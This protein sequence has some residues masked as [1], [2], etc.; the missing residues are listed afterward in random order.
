MHGKT[1][2]FVNKVNP[3]VYNPFLC[4]HCK[5]GTLKKFMEVEAI[6]NVYKKAVND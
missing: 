3:A 2:T 5:K 4:P 6:N 1:E